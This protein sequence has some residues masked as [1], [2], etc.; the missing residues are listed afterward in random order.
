MPMI[1]PQPPRSG[2][3]CANCACFYELPSPQNPLQKGGF[4]SRSPAQAAAV[5]MQI[6]RLDKEGKPVLARLDQKPV[7]DSIEDIAWTHAPM[8]ASLGCFDGWRPVGA[9]PGETRR[10]FRV[11]Q[12]VEALRPALEAA[13]ERVDVQALGLVGLTREGLRA[14]LAGFDDT[15]PTAANDATAQDAAPQPAAPLNS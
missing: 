12:A 5:R 7:M 14:L 6:P 8:A 15:P 1:P 11:R 9:L 13:I 2:R 4:C 3:T 10:D